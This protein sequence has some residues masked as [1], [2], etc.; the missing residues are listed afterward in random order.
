M[1]VERPGELD[2]PSDGAPRRRRARSRWRPSCP[3]PPGRSARRRRPRRRTVGAARSRDRRRARRRGARST[4]APGR[5]PVPIRATTLGRPSSPRTISGVPPRSV[6]D[7]RPRPRPGVLG[8]ARVLARRGDQSL[9]A[10]RSDLVRAHAAR[11]GAKRRPHLPWRRMYR[12]RRR[13]RLAGSLDPAPAHARGRATGSPRCW[14]P[15]VEAR[16]A[17]SSP[18]RP[19]TCRG[20]PGRSRSR[21]GSRRTRSGSWPRPRCAR[22][23]RRSG[24]SPSEVR[25]SGRSAGAHVRLGDPG[26]AVRRRGSGCPGVRAQRGRDPQVLTIRSTSSRRPRPR[27]SGRGTGRCSA[28]SRTRCA[29]GTRSGARRPRCCIRCSSGSGADRDRRRRHCSRATRAAVDPGRRPDDRGR[30]PVVEPATARRTRSPRTCSPG[31]PDRA[32]QPERDRG[33]GR[34]GVR[35]A[36][37]HPRGDPRSTWWTC[38]GA[39]STRPRSPNRRCAIGAKVLWLQEGIVNEEAAGSRRRRA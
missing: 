33:A 28:G 25:C 13:T 21:V 35:V 7:V 4:R 24:W 29:T 1:E 16:A 36:P 27:W 37:G 34:A 30:R 18:R 39:P 22:R 14:L 8:A 20:T 3:P 11:R 5:S 17:S 19:N 31:L 26:R 32:G 6:E 12:E 10:N 23:T 2:R 15:L 38:S 9:R